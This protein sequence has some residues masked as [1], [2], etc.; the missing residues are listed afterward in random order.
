MNRHF[1]SQAMVNSLAI[2]RIAISTRNLRLSSL[3]LWTAAAAGFATAPC[4][5]R[6]QRLVTTCS[7]AC[8]D[9]P[10]GYSTQKTDSFYMHSSHFGLQV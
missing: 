3:R 7:V 4:A 2:A 9:N 5:R 6:R 10:R 8:G 1:R